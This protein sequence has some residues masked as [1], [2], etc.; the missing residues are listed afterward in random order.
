M[1]R[2]DLRITDAWLHRDQKP[3]LYWCRQNPGLGVRVGK[4][5]T[6]AFI[7][8]RSGG[9]RVTLA[10]TREMNLATAQEKAR[11]MHGLGVP[12]GTVGAA[13]DEWAREQRLEGNSETTI[14]NRRLQLEKHIDFG[15]PL[16]RLNHAF[17]KGLRNRIAEDSIWAAND[18][19]RHLRT[20]Y[21]G[22]TGRDWTVDLKPLKTEK[23]ESKRITMPEDVAAWWAEIRNHHTA[24]FWLLVSM[25]G[26]R[27]NDALTAHPRNVT[28]GW[29]LLPDTKSGR[30]FRYPLPTQI[31]LPTDGFIFSEPRSGLKKLPGPH[32]VRHWWRYEAE[33]KVACP[34]P[35]LM[36]LMDHSSK[37]AVTDRYGQRNV[38]NEDLA[39]WA[40][41]IADHIAEKIEL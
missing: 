15:L 18:V 26:L 4:T 3:G 24:G 13:F 25:T 27:R 36:R 19:V 20:I 30:E 40:Q 2:S 28:D 14:S 10:R 38:N 37:R 33:T 22:A 34:F 29:L 9:K 35:I 21:R 23:L 32:A 16:T 7:F 6:K 31:T 8:Q 41:R 1:A 39:V 5:G 17:V 11:E 12:I